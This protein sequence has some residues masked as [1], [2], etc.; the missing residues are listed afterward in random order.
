[1]NQR[2]IS[3]FSG[4]G[5]KSEDAIAISS[6]VW[7]NSQEIYRHKNSG[8]RR[9]NYKLSEQIVLN[10]YSHVYYALSHCRH[11]NE[12]DDAEECLESRGDTL[13]Y[14][15]NINGSLKLFNNKYF[16]FTTRIELNLSPTSG[17]IKVR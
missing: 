16:S 2:L 11:N 3:D 13:N 9:R 12:H 7:E 15:R 10:F 17:R 8:F 1:M 5:W 6:G 4:E 14:L